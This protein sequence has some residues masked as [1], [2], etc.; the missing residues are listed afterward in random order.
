[1]YTQ[2]L[3]H[4]RKLI[5]TYSLF[6]SSLPCP[7]YTEVSLEF[8]TVGF[9]ENVPVC[10]THLFWFSEEF[11]FSLFLYINFPNLSLFQTC[12]TLRPLVFLVTRKVFL[13]EIS[14]GCGHHQV[15]FSEWCAH[16][17]LFFLLKMTFSC[18]TPPT[19]QKERETI[20]PNGHRGFTAGDRQKAPA[21]AH[22]KNIWMIS[23]SEGRFL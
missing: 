18:N 8:F 6:Y 11:F 16:V 20:K 17:C 9:G 2:G 15:I 1:M 22:T 7:S 3:V 14:Y 10:A 21:G 12:W 23:D 4:Y 5:H 19:L 13:S